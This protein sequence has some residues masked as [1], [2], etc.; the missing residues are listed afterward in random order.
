[1][2]ASRLAGAVGSLARRFRAHDEERVELSRFAEEA[3][4]AYEQVTRQAL[5][6]LVRQ[7]DRLETKLNGIL[8]G[9]AGSLLIDLYRV[10]VRGG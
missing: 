6:D 3:P 7:V 4:S 8:L 9:L 5:E 2:A 10:I 1:M